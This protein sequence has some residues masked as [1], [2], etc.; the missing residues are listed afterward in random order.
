MDSG[1]N[2]GPGV[3]GREFCCRGLKLT[4]RKTLP[5]ANVSTAV[6]NTTFTGFPS[7]AT[8]HPKCAPTWGEAAARALPLGPWVEPPMGP[9]RA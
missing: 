9:R 4:R 2:P 8:K 7:G 3:N 6:V 1:R 5:D